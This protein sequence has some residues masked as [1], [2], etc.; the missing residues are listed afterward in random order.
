MKSMSMNK[1]YYASGTQR[2]LVAGAAMRVT[3]PNPLLPVSGG[4]GPSAPVKTKRG[5]I[6]VRVLYLMQ[7]NTPLAFVGI[8][9][10]GFP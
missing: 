8:D 1:K 2:S 5:E 9:A 7:G 3:T 4:L 6:G 10:L